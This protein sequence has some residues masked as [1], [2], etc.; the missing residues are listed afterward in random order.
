MTSMAKSISKSDLGDVTRSRR[1]TVNGVVRI[2]CKYTL[3][4]CAIFTGQNFAQTFDW[5]FGRHHLLG[6]SILY[7]MVGAALVDV[8]SKPKP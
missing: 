6:C 2:I 3:I 5:E 7:G 4:M 1:L 8:V